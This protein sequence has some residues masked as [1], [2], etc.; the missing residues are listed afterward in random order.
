M[1]GEGLHYILSEKLIVIDECVMIWGAIT[2]N[3]W[4]V[5]FFSNCEYHKQRN[6]SNLSHV[7]PRGTVIPQPF[8]T[9]Y[10]RQISSKN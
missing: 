4:A 6:L 1:T 2:Y 8:K 3:E 10:Q 9:V 7:I 5:G